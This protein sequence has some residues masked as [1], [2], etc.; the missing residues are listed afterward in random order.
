M[1]PVSVLAML[2]LVCVVATSLVVLTMLDDVQTSCATPSPAR[3]GGARKVRPMKSGTY[4]LASGFG[5]RGGGEFHQG[6]DWAASAGTPIYAA[7]DG[8]V[9]AAGP[10]TGF[11]AWIVIDSNIGGEAMSTVYGHMF[12]TSSDMLV[13]VNDRVHAGQQ[14]ARVGYNGSTDPPGPDGA[15]LHFETWTGGGRLSGGTPIDPQTWLA[16]AAEPGGATPPA[17]DISTD[18]TKNPDIAVAVPGPETPLAPVPADR[19][20]EANLQIDAIRVMRTLAV[21][22]PEITTFGG[23]REYDS[24]PDHPS[25]R[26]VD[27]MIPD[28]TSGEGKAL[29]DSVSDFVLANADALHV[30]YII[31]RQVY[32][33]AHGE[34]QLMT[35]AGWGDTANHMDHVHITTAGGGYPDSSP[36]TGTA[37]SPGTAP[38]TGGCPSVPVD[39]DLAPGVVPPE[40][41]PWYRKAGSLCPQIPA[42]ML[43]AQGKQESGFN[44]RAGSEAGAQGIAQF[45]P[46]TAAAIDPDDGQPYVIDA[47]GDGDASVW[48]PPD[49]I[50]GQG[51]YMCAIAKHVDTWIAEGKVHAPAGPAE[52]YLAA[53]NAGEGAVLS[54]GGFPSGASDYQVQ[55]RP[56]V[57]NILAM[58]PQFAKTLS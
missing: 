36:I 19:G 12:D 58:T 47:D 13:G 41:E 34:P 45:L 49:A 10:A 31:W 20:S 17:P 26:A 43:A 46:G 56:Y 25:G 38:T 11:G 37:R 52:L 57:D 23:W 9:V 24:L 27:V 2:V 21:R 39:D 53:Y 33:P 8:V 7:A 44:P 4:V 3:A 15:H 14:I 42:S 22:F 6:L 40:Y 28:Y 5:P 51:R 50:I 48:D 29:G 16:D 18:A 30:D 35:N 1:R 32:H 54:S 55:T